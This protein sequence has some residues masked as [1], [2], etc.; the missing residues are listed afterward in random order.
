MA[1]INKPNKWLAGV[2]A[3]LLSPPFGL[4]YAAKWRWAIV[5]FVGLIVVV[6]TYFALGGPE[7][8][9]ILFPLIALVGVIHAFI[10]AMRYPVGSTRPW[11]SKGYSVLGI[12]FSF[13][14]LVFVVRAFFFEP[15]RMASSAMLPTI[16][17]GKHVV[18]SKWGYGNKAAYGLTIRQG[19]VTAPIRHGDVLVFIYPRSGERR[20]YLMRVVGLPGDI[21]EYKNKALAINGHAAAYRD[22]GAYNYVMPTG[23]VTA[24]LKSENIRSK[25]YRVLHRPDVPAIFL[26][27][28][29][30][31]PSQTNC[32]YL[33]EGFTCRIPEKHYFM[34]GDNR[35]A[36]NDSRYWGF[37]P[38]DHIVGKVINLPQ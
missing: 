7:S 27:S 32:L 31:F 13:F 33:E 6:A 21:V 2:I 4:L 23:T 8:L 35:D 9:A 34:M 16:A 14:L 37:V 29:S 28:V 25:E 12:L 30:N 18:A 38:E 1:T 3:L 36:S 17:K 20:D 19:A 5:Y 24:R 22:L 11:Y 10:A 26:D 15:F